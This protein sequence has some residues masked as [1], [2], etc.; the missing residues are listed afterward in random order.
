MLSILFALAFLVRKLQP[1]TLNASWQ[2]AVFKFPFQIHC[3]WIWAASFVN[4]NVLL[5]S[6]E[7]GASLQE[8]AA[9]TS[10]GLLA[11]VAA[12]YLLI[13]KN[14]VVP[15]VVAW[16]SYAVRVELE[17]PIDLISSTFDAD[18]IGRLSRSAM[19]LAIF[20]LVSTVTFGAYQFYQQRKSGGSSSGGASSPSSGDSETPYGTMNS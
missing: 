19:A 17:A 18:T 4:A 8:I 13:A 11:M 1:V 3:G 20:A 12:Y 9:W 7:L 2:W 14:Y 6:M 5:V 10:L 15:S 16:A